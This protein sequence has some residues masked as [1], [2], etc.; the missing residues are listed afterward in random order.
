MP[1]KKSFKRQ[2]QTH[3]KGEM[4]IFPRSSAF[5]GSFVLLCVNVPNNFTAFC[6]FVYFFRETSKSFQEEAKLTYHNS[7]HIS[8]DPIEVT[9]FSCSFVTCYPN[10][11]ASTFLLD[12]RKG[13]QTKQ[14]STNEINQLGNFLM[15]YHKFRLR[16][17]GISVAWIFSSRVLL[18]RWL[19]C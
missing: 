1:A 9:L 13:T 2:N 8:S 11:W 14:K 5:C 12:T 15:V 19:A 7:Y 17:W 16:C 10:R 18:F 3:I 6:G 4:K